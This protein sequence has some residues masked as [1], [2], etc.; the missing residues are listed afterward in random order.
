MGGSCC[1]CS[2]MRKVTDGEGRRR[3]VVSRS[4]SS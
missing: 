2:R 1:S 3:E 4:S